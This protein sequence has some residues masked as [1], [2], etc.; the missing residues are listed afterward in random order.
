MHDAE[1]FGHLGCCVCSFLLCFL[2]V[3]QY[4]SLFCFSDALSTFVILD[5]TALGLV[6]A[7]FC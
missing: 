4:L 6:W 2:C 3:V 7:T 5:A 1:Q